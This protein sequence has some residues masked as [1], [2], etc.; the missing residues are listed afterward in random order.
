METYLY[1]SLIPEALIFSHL[2]PDRFGMYLANGT[3]RQSEGPA[4]FFTVRQDADLSALRVEEGRERCQPHPD[5]SPR[6]SVYVAI[7]NV[8]ARVPLAAL[9]NAYLTTSA[10]FTLELEQAEWDEGSKDLFYLY[11]ELGPVYPRVASRLEPSAFCRSVT[12]PEPLVSVPRLAF[13]DLRLGGLA[14]DPEAV[15]GEPLPYRNVEHLKQCLHY[16]HRHPDHRTKIVNRE[17]SPEVP[18]YMIRS[19]L[20]VGDAGGM[21]YYPLPAEDTLRRDHYLWWNSARVSRGY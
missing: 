3:K 6:M 11:Q 13:M 10:G 21:H 9:G 2:P 1:L 4:V 17:P 7:H 5:G 15:G 12:S 19:G 16:I 18:F 14:E 8:L 20:F